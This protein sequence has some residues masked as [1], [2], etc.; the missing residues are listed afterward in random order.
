MSRISF[1]KPAITWLV[2]K[3]RTDAK[4]FGDQQ[5]APSFPNPAPLNKV[6]ITMPQLEQAS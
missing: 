4:G 5:T 3:K 6:L 2:A 1:N